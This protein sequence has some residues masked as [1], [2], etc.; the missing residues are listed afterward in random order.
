MR[1][2]IDM[3]GAQTES[4]FRGIGR[5]TLSQVKA[6]IRNRGEHEIILALN[7]LFPDTI[8]QIRADFYDLLPQENIR[9]WYALGPVRECEPGNTWRRKT[10]EL[11]REAFFNSLQPD[12]IHIT[13][14]FEGYVDDAVTSIKIFDCRIPVSV[15]LYDLIPLLNPELY[16]KPNP[17]YKEYYLRKINFLKKA[18]LLLGI[19]NSTCREGKTMLGI[20]AKNVVNIS[21]AADIHFK[22][23]SI[24]ESDE[25]ELRDKFGITKPFLLYTGG[26][27]PRK[28][29]PHLIQ[30]YAKLSLELRSQHQLLLVGKMP[31]GDV[32]SLRQ[33]ADDAGLHRDELIFSGHVTDDELAQLYNLCKLFVFP[34]LHEGFGLPA[35][36]A[37][38]CGVPV[39]GANV[40]SLPEV[41]GLDEALFDPFDIVAISQK[42]SLVLEDE[43]FSH[44]LRE[45]GMKQ[46][47]KFCWDETA[48]STIAAWETLRPASKPEYLM[49][50]TA[51][52]R[53]IANL[54]EYIEDTDDQ[55]LP[56]ASCI[57]INRQNGIERQLLLDVSELSQHDAATGV[58]RVVRSYLGWLL[59]SPHPGFR[60]EPVYATRE[61]GYCYAR[62]Y[63][64]RFLGLP[65]ADVTDEPIRWQR[66]DIFF[67]LDMQ[68]HVQL[69][70][71]A[72]YQQLRREGVT[73]KFLIYDLLPIQLADLFRDSDASALHAS[74]LAMVATMDGAIS[75]SRATADA[76][77]EWL[78]DNSIS[79][80]PIFQNSWVHIGADIEDSQPS[81]G[82]L[83][84][85]ATVLNAIQS[86]LT[87]LCVATLEPRK[88]QK[89]ILEAIE[90]LWHEGNDINLVFVGQQGWKIESLIERIQNHP[91]NSRRLFWLK[92]VSDEYLER[93]YAVSTCLIAASI[94]EGFG[95]PLIE[96]ARHGTPII[97]R[98]I[99]VFREIAEDCAY[100]FS[101]ETPDN[102]AQALKDWMDLHQA[103]RQPDSRQIHWS[104]WQESTKRLKIA[105]I[106]EYY[107]RKQL[108]VDISELVQNDANSGIQRVVRNVLREWLLNPPSGWRVEPVY[109]TTEQG[110]RYARNFTSVFLGCSDNIQVDEPIEFRAGDLFLGLDLQPQVVATNRSFYQLLRRHGV[111]V[112][113][114][115]YDLLCL[116]MPH[117]FV[118]GGEE[119]HQCWLEVVA[120][121]DG[122]I[123]ISKAVA[124]ELSH[125]LEE[126]GME[127]LRPFDISWFHLGADIQN[128]SPSM[129]LP[130]EA[131][132]IL[133]LID[134]SPSFLEV[135]TIEPRKG[136]AQ[137]LVAFEQ[138]W[139]NGVD[140][141]LVIVG[142]EGW[143]VEEL[144][145]RLRG[146]PELNKRLF[147]LEG[148]SD[149]YLEKIYAAS[150]CL[151]AASEGEGFGL[152]LIEA[153]QHKLPIIA[154]D[155]PVFREVADDHAFYFANKNDP[156]TMAVACREWISL[157]ESHQ[158]PESDTMPWLTWKESAERLRE[159]V[160]S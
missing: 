131:D 105:L 113:F 111:K 65:D 80:A 45:H 112:Q 66:G 110:Y 103:G 72:F 151:I 19:S 42:M 24:S 35:L 140:V 16:L 154:R 1:I 49:C 36:E 14:L 57:A 21:T 13:S 146:H 124:D 136:H 59:R 159:I 123:C 76:Y 137:S 15:T 83:P 25:K 104:T 95:L 100:Y 18:S 92:G 139:E 93:V 149:E 135:G 153:A 88:G 107:S 142:K 7:G 37:M 134:S 44:R 39:I 148:I 77:G 82:L 141:N 69:A 96:A 158:H 97:A 106:E 56:L 155:I 28:N 22:T 108:L 27:D 6:L 126:Y 86:R 34:S 94:N 128:S 11:I 32:F 144:V 73:V 3:Q 90:Q 99:P 71:D 17:V 102:L 91:E 109:A 75:I 74:W 33:V 118:T 84:D 78:H 129:G 101:G 117:H 125:W 64:Q 8:E 29:L 81:K 98:D 50:S 60:I 4:R 48:K 85:T 116:S 38:A 156:T 53:L 5:Y 10:A 40:S 51:D 55:L 122:A 79:T 87:F 41:I 62:S 132:K 121:S 23:I 58:Q 119:G 61:K 68:H 67:G 120:E 138:L 47:R 52:T 63:T 152:P 46:A 54:S 2:V 143:K 70:H 130:Q 160:F 31:E 12:V 9:V 89:Q 145:A 127:R 150:T 30:A 43:A 114:I 26:S 20:S 147:W 115:V 133:N 157:Y